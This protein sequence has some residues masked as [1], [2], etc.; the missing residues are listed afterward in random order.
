MLDRL[1]DAARELSGHPWAQGAL[2]ALATL[3]LEDPATVGS[4]LLVAG[5]HMGFATAFLGLTIG[6]AGGDVGLYLAGAAVGPSLARRGW[7]DAARLE[8]AESW[9]A[10]NV[11][12]A[13]LLSRFVPGMRLPTYLAAGALRAPFARFL[14]VV[15]VASVVWT[16]VLLSLTVA[17]GS[18]LLPWMGRLRWLAIAAIVLAVIVIP[19][20]IAKRAGRAAGADDASSRPVVSRFE[21]WPPWLFYAPVAL[22]WAWLSVRYRGVLLPSAANPTIH[23]GGLIGESKGAILDLVEGPARSFVA[24][25]VRVAMREGEPLDDRVE[26]CREAMTAAGLALPAVFKPDKGQRGAG[27]RPVND[28]AEM[29]A[30]VEGFP[31]GAELVIQA[32]VG[33]GPERCRGALA[34]ELARRLRGIREAGVLYWRSPGE[35]RGT[36]SSITLKRMPEVVG[37]GVATVGE[38]I[39]RDPRA[40]RLRELYGA[41]HRDRLDRV[42][43]PGDVLPL[44]FVGNHCRGAVFLD[45]TDLVTPEMV[46]T[47]DRIADAIPGFCFGRFDVRFDDASEFLAGR[48]FKIVEINGAGAEATHIWDASARLLDAYGTLFEQYAVLF[49]LGAENRE[50][51]ARPIGVRAFLRDVFEYRRLAR[52]YPEAR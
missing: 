16:A 22:W 12:A 45:G 6:I 4:G 2:A 21:F 28:A 11:V 8:R 13:V 31:T 7:V 25:Y 36:V 27:V 10:R 19:R 40:R 48:G 30:Y 17:L 5:G 1:I 42:L 26:R 3:V 51:G 9:F 38:L 20:S 35:S 49:R 50:R 15:V 24:D 37:D 39:D 33:T 41:R 32:W 23:A 52:A 18:A 46:A 34:P 14:T 43:A 44:V 47:F 29:R